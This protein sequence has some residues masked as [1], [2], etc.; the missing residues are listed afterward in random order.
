M[1]YLN[2]RQKELSVLKVYPRVIKVFRNYNCIIPSSAP[3]ERM[4]LVGGG[5]F[6]RK[7]NM[8]GDGMFEKYDEAVMNVLCK[9]F[10]FCILTEVKFNFL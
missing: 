6:T 9:I 8:L 4:F 5:I 3:A 10:S 2:E 7:R 1:S